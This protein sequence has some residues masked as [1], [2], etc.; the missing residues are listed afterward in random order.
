MEIGIFSSLLNIFKVIFHSGETK[1]TQSR[2]QIH[3]KI[4]QRNAGKKFLRCNR[5]IILFYV[6]EML[7][8]SNDF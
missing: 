7:K 4:E 8:L 6:K 5:A 3:Q 1:T 2:E